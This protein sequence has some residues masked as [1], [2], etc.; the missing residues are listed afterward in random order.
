[1]RIIDLYRE[2]LAKKVKI[3]LYVGPQAGECICFDKMVAMAKV[4]LT[5]G[6]SGLFA[7]RGEMHLDVLRSFSTCDARVRVTAKDGDILADGPAS[8]WMHFA[9]P[10][11]VK[12]EVIHVREVTIALPVRE[13]K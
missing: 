12:G 6:P 8:V 7:N 9:Y 5:E 11:Q 2:K 4:K 10:K 13:E 3:E 1:M